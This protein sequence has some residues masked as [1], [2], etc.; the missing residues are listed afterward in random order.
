[1]TPPRICTGCRAK[2]QAYHGR[3]LCYD[4]KP[5]SKGRPRPCR[6]CGAVGDY[7]TSGLCRRCHQYAP[8]R[9]ESCRDCDAWG[10]ERIDKWL[11]GGCKGWRTWHRGRTGQ[12]VGCGRVRTINQRGACRLCWQHAKQTRG[13]AETVAGVD[14]AAANRDG[15][16]LM[17]ANVSSSKNGHRPH[18]RHNRPRPH[19]RVTDRVPLD[20]PFR[21]PDRTIPT[22]QLDL[23]ASVPV[24]DAARRRGMPHPPNEVLAEQLDGLVVAHASRHSWNAPMRQH[25]RLGLRVLLGSQQITALPIR[26]TEVEHLIAMRFSARPVLNVLH[27]AG[28]LD[29]DRA[30][31]RLTAWFDQR[32]AGL[33]GP[34]VAELWTWLDTLHNGSATP[35][36]SRPRAAGTIRTRLLWAMPVLQGWAAAGHTSLREITREHILDALP[37]AGTPRATVGAAL[38]SIF[39]T[40]KARKVTFVNPMARITVGNFERRTPLPADTTRL[41]AILTAPAP[42]DAALAAL[43]VFHGLRPREL[44]ELLL[45]DYRDGQ[46]HLR[47]RT[48]RLAAPARI[49][50]DG[51]LR[52]RR[53]R[54]PHTLNPHFFVHYLSAPTLGPVSRYWVNDHL[55]V[56]ARQLRQDRIVDEAIST[57]GDIRRICDFFGVTT[58]TAEHYIS[59]LDNPSPALATIDDPAAAD[60]GWRTQHPT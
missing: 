27:D 18:P 33:P 11:C 58:T 51:F 21:L 56:A 50:L 29:D 36:R 57:R 44:R 30:R 39:S 38:R 17:L 14:V 42:P 53:E 34:M 3:Q 46:L 7:W 48:I 60:P 32:V 28:L 59:V 5:G 10:V 9:P 22:G 55:G 4:C 6:R 49:K 43:A 24:I 8:Q 15:Q 19:L 13:H 47:D 35:P 26:A 45:I 31:R 2:P 54:W 41:R 16:Q 52:H 23:L 25:T 12:C 40:L 37:P 20:V 1:M